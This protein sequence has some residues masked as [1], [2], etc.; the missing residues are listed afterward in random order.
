MSLGADKT[1]LSDI[2]HQK[3][4]LAS[5]GQIFRKSQVLFFLFLRGIS[6]CEE[7]AALKLYGTIQPL[8][9]IEWE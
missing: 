5:E 9:M 2:I 6:A 8:P 4:T 1:V 7:S 3:I